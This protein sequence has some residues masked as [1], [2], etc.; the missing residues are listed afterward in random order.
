MPPPKPSHR[1]ATTI[2]RQ[3]P[4]GKNTNNTNSCA[5][6]CDKFN[7]SPKANISTIPTARMLNTLA[8]HRKA[9]SETDIF[10]IEPFT[11]SLLGLTTQ[12][13]ATTERKA[14]RESGT[15]ALDAVDYEDALRR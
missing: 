12:N 9:Q 2:P 5:V 4:S 10:L 1:H 14:S 6:K 7:P 11:S 8:D 15:D 13:Y 3:T